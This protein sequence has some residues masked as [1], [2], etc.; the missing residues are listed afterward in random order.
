MNFV[1]PLMR[2]VFPQQIAQQL[3]NVQPMPAP[4]GLAFA[5]NY[6]FDKWK[7]EGVTIVPYGKVLHDEIDDTFFW[8]VIGEE[9]EDGRIRVYKDNKDYFYKEDGDVLTKEEFEERYFLEG[10]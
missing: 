9:L 3:V 8:K 2:R 7:S 5:L 4:S 6:K 1:M 10:L